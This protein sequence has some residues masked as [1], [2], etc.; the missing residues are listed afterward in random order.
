MKLG[1][2]IDTGGT[3]TDAVVYRFA[4]KAVLV[5]TPNYSSLRNSD[6]VSKRIEALGIERAHVINRMSVQPA[7]STLPGVEEIERVLAIPLAG[8]ISE[9]PNVDLGNNAGR[10][11]VSAR[12]SYIAKN[13]EGIAAR[14]GL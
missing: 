9:D 3:Y 4:D 6:T 13:F 14:L 8:I 12:G 10:P 11:G 1:I 5:V 2:G 7:G